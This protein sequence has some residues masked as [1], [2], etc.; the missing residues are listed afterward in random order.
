MVR[1]EQ[2]QMTLV[3]FIC[4]HSSQHPEMRVWLLFVR[5]FRHPLRWLIC[6]T[7]QGD[8]DIIISHL[9][10]SIC[11]YID[12][13]LFLHLLSFRFFLRDCEVQHGQYSSRV[14]FRLQHENFWHSTFLLLPH[15]CV[16]NLAMVK[17]W[18][19]L[20][21]AVGKEIGNCR[22]IDGWPSLIFFYHSKD[23]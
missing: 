10:A 14:H 18:C 12:T 5:L 22:Q 20:R 7:R 17:Q 23:C 19:F 13:F 16:T 2:Q 3:S 8:E 1:A 4:W 11:R 6:S 21:P 9:Y 15:F